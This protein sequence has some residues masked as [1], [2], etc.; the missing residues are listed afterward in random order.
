LSGGQAI[1][2]AQTLTI[3][4]RKLLIKALIDRAE[5]PSP[6]KPKRSLREFRGV[7]AHLYNGTDAQEA[8]NKIRSEWG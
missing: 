7:A 1:Q 2:V 4:K 5:E 3:N 8:V 6:A